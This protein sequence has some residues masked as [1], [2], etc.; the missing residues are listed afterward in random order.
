MADKLQSG[1]E[2]DRKID[3][4]VRGKRHRESHSIYEKKVPTKLMY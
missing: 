3:K 4:C 1:L 2:V